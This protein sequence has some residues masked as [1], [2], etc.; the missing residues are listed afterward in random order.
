MYDYAQKEK[1]TC[2]HNGTLTAAA[3]V[4]SKWCSG[5]YY[6]NEA[7][8]ALIEVTS[9]LPYVVYLYVNKRLPN[10]GLQIPM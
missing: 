9:Y 8:V 4:I 5:V 7:I 3:D 10:C 1:R 2:S 6:Y